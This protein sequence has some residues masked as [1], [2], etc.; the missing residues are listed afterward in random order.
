[1]SATLFPLVPTTGKLIVLVD[2]ED[3]K[4]A[5]GIIKPD[6]ALQPAN[7]ATVMA[8]DESLCFRVGA[9]VV[10]GKYSGVTVDYAGI[11]YVVLKHEDVL[12]TVTPAPVEVALVHP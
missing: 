6:T 12:A 4:T 8:V 3:E 2:Q 1:M 10:I 11:A 7:L 5:G 9:R